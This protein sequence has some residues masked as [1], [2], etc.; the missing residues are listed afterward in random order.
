MTDK[1]KTT[2]EKPKLQGII[3]RWLILPKLL[4]FMLNLLVYS[5]HAFQ[6]KFY[7]KNWNFTAYQ[8][9]YMMALQCF[10]FLGSIFWS[11]LADRTGKHRTITIVNAF[12]FCALN[13]LMLVHFFDSER[14]TGKL[15]ITGLNTLSGIFLSGL[16][17]LVD[18]QVVGILS[19]DGSFSKDIFGRQRLW[20]SISHSVATGMS[21]GLRTLYKSEGGMFIGMNT[22]AILFVTSVWLA[23][24]GDLK[25]E[26]GKPHHGG[27]EKKKDI[28]APSPSPSP[29]GEGQKAQEEAQIVEAAMAPTPAPAPPVHVKESAVKVK[30]PTF[31][32]LSMPA[33]L[34]FLCFILVAGYTRS[35][36]TIYQKYFVADVLRK[37][38]ESSVYLDIF[39]AV[40]E[41]GTFF[42]AQQIIGFVGVHWALI[43][44]QLAG[45][46]R[47][48]VYGMYSH[49]PENE[50]VRDGII[51]GAEL[52]K[53]INT[54]LMVSSAVKIV[55]EMAPKGCENTAQ[56]LFSGT[57]AGLSMAVSGI[58]GGLLLHV[59]P[60]NSKESEIQQDSSRFEGMFLVSTIAC[61]LLIIAF[62]VKY[63][64][65]DK[66]ILTRKTTPKA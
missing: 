15:W 37:N 12:I 39:R 30:N 60:V 5:L 54:G 4:Y 1:D 40:S 17:P 47:M 2:M 31:V 66:V 27:G 65:V 9:G 18:A 14:F 52:L 56:G 28:E 21:N 23:V 55:T 49:L 20:G 32:L 57:Y 50:M 22:A 53:G 36:M 59:W 29:L 35:I 13:T 10:N 48:L 43:V 46:I 62:T 42:F 16:F 6:T 63:A 64:V 33:F 3:H 58:L 24:P 45:L 25:I 19:K 7:I 34:F 11:Q 26:K 38:D 44:S 41:V 61:F 51:Y 8:V